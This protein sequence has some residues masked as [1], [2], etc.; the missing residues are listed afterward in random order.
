MEGWGG[1]GRGG[2]MGVGKGWR[3]WVWQV[4]ARGSRVCQREGGGWV[5]RWA[6]VGYRV[7]WGGGGVGRMGGGGC[8]VGV[9]GIGGVLGWV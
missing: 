1:G 4:F 6:W 7:G 8:C 9:G 3:E 5:A 2:E